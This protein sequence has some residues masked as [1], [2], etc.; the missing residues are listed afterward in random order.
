M[1]AG[2]SP[3]TDGEPNALGWR[4]VV[5][6]LAIDQAEAR[7]AFESVDV[8]T[9]S[10]AVG[11]LSMATRSHQLP[12]VR[13]PLALQ[14]QLGDSTLQRIDVL[15]LL[16][17][18]VNRDRRQLG[19]ISPHSLG[20]LDLDLGSGVAAHGSA[21]VDTEVGERVGAVFGAIGGAASDALCGKGLDLVVGLTVLKVGDLALHL[22][23]LGFEVAQFLVELPRFGP[24]K[25]GHRKPR[26][27]RPSTV[28]AS[29][30]ELAGYMPI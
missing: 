19:D 30:R 1:C 24:G 10:A 17:V 3:W 16:R 7:L 13:I 20:K 9:D 8:E 12:R 29:L 5:G 21:D 22:P 6:L 23:H 25:E 28:I 27:A 15:S 26:I 18:G 2:G 11:Q 14:E 4:S